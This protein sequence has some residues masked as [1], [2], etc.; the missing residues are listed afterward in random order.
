MDQRKE[1]E[2]AFK[3]N[4]FFCHLEDKYIRMLSGITTVKSFKKGETII[5]EGEKAMGLYIVIEGIVKIYKISKDGKEHIIHIFGEGEIFAEVSLAEN[6]T[7]PAWAEALTDVKI[8]FIPRDLILA[9]LRK[10]PTLAL[11]MI[12]VCIL[13]LKNLVLSIENIKMK[14]ARERTLFFLWEMT[15]KGKKSEVT[16]SIT[17]NQLSLLLGITPETFSR[18]I[19]K[20]KEENIILKTSGNRK[21]ILAIDKLKESLKR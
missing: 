17:Q 9:N 11:A 2:N 10:D 1:I 13:R 3:N 15:E 21:F 18:I 12:G 7:Y 14:N 16:F 8:G 4:L 19:K 5:K 6:Q 20:L